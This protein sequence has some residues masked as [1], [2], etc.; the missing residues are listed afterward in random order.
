MAKVK[1]GGPHIIR[2]K[3]PLWSLYSIAITYCMSH[4]KHECTFI[5]LN[6]IHKIS[7][8]TYIIKTEI[9]II[10]ITYFFSLFGQPADPPVAIN[11][12]VEQIVKTLHCTF[13]VLV[14]LE[15][16]IYSPKTCLL[17]AG[18]VPM[19]FTIIW[20][21]LRDKHWLII[22][23]EEITQFQNS[24]TLIYLVLMKR[25]QEITYFI[26]AGVYRE[27]V[28][29]ESLFGPELGTGLVFREGWV[30]VCHNFLLSPLMSIVL[31]HLHL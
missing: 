1:A 25:F 19:H 29:N 28:L 8:F 6:R 13:N 14:E 5:T 15:V 4:W 16:F 22:M 10:Y 9:I 17:H 3:Y 31:F 27:I 20:S 11:V 21:S 23:M 2:P 24:K 7:K 18:M 30:N 26:I 12:L